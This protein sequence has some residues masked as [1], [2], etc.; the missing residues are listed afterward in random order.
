MTNP[1][2]PKQYVDAIMSGLN[3]RESDDCGLNPEIYTSIQE[4]EARFDYP[5]PDTEP[6]LREWAN[7][8]STRQIVTAFFDYHEKWTWDS[9]TERDREILEFLKEEV[10]RRTVAEGDCYFDTRENV[11]YVFQG[12]RWIIMGA[13]TIGMSTED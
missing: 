12:Q 4:G 9:G 6:D 11:I 8:L 13:A 10:N 5:C 1:A 7:V 2:I 3:W